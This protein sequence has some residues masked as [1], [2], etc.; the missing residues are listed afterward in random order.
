MSNTLCTSSSLYHRL[1]HGSSIGG[2]SSSSAGAMAAASSPWLSCPPSSCCCGCG[3]C[4]GE[5]WR[6]SCGEALFCCCK[7]FLLSAARRSSSSA[8]RRSASATDSSCT[9][10]RAEIRRLRRRGRP[11]PSSTASSSSP[12]GS[13]T[14]RCTP[15]HCSSTYPKS[16]ASSSLPPRSTRLFPRTP[17]FPAVL[18]LPWALCSALL[19]TPQAISAKRRCGAVDAFAA[20]FGGAAERAL[21][22][23]RLSAEHSE[24]LDRLLAGC[25]YTRFCPRH[26]PSTSSAAGRL[27]LAR[28]RP[29][30]RLRDVGLPLPLCSPP[31][32]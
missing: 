24:E 6:C 14:M 17:P 19:P 26:S 30:L 16:S 12:A 3:L 10:T 1:S 13:S 8:T 2:L 29:G 25:I 21:R 9:R 4:D 32:R 20:L 31:R 5:S 7:R 23:E 11:P 22:G 18:A 28:P 27:R 15:S